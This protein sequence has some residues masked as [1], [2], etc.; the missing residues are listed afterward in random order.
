LLCARDLERTD[1]IVVLRVMCDLIPC[2]LCRASY[3]YWHHTYP[4]GEGGNSVEWLWFIHDLVNGKLGKPRPP[5]SKLLARLA[6]FECGVSPFDVID[7]LLI[8]ARYINPE[9]NESADA[10]CRLIPIFTNITWPVNLRPRPM[11][12]GPTAPS[13][14]ALFDHL[15]LCKQEMLCI[16]G[17]TARVLEREYEWPLYG[18]TLPTPVAVVPFYSMRRPR[19]TPAVRSNRGGSEAAARRRPAAG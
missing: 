11:P 2:A 7:T 8:M 14:G 13:A 5:L 19:G 12:R 4:L 15:L 1:V 16:A 10:L 18:G 9:S 3:R 6:R 17:R